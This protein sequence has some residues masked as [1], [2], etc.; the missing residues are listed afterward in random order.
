MRYICSRI[1]PIADLSPVNDEEYQTNMDIRLSMTCD[2]FL[3][4]WF[5]ASVHTSLTLYNKA[6]GLDNQRFKQGIE[7]KHAYVKP[8][9]KR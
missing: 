6:L 9:K 3:I 1:H 8:L 4:G 2:G 5:M 7:I